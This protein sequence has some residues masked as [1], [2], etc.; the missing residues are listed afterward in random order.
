MKS[1]DTVLFDL[2]GTLTD[3]GKGITNSVAYALKKYG[4]PIDDPKTLY[5]FIGPP[6]TDS[7]Q[8]YYGFSEKQ[9]VE[10]VGFYREYYTDKGIFENAVYEGIPE[11]LESL[12]KAGKKILLAT[13]KPE[14][15]AKQILRHFGLDGYFTC[16][17]GA[18]LDSSR[19]KKDAVIAYALEKSGVTNRST[20]VMIGDREYDILAAKAFGL[21]SIGVLFG[22]GSKE[23]LTAAGAT[24]LAETVEEIEYYVN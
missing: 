11:L 4:I 8:K 21:D 9:A 20:A 10:A 15:F 12:Q 5:G 13:S 14:V 3:P 23:E 1:Y 22:Y 16:V 24:Y 18:T 19:V 7:F 6:L 2:D 17:A